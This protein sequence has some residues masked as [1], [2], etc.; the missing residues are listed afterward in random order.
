MG[1]IFKFVTEPAGSSLSVDLPAA[2]RTK[3]KDFDAAL[4][5]IHSRIDEIMVNQ[6]ATWIDKRENFDEDKADKDW[7]SWVSSL[8]AAGL[9]SGLERPLYHLLLAVFGAIPRL[10]WLPAKGGGVRGDKKQPCPPVLTKTIISGGNVDFYAFTDPGS[11]LGWE[12]KVAMGVNDKW[13]AI[14]QCDS[15]MGLGRKVGCHVLTDLEHWRFFQLT[16]GHNDDGKLVSLGS[17]LLGCL[18]CV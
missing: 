9:E 18:R 16:R 14:V 7:W 11:F 13:Q 8:K 4:T 2:A 15:L 1:K 17:L 10:N 6:S 12:L 3:F 5:G